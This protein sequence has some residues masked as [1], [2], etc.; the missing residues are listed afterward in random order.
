M[1]A[2][3]GVQFACETAGDITSATEVK[4]WARAALG[5]GNGQ[6]NLTV[7]FVSENEGADLN[8]RYRQRT[9]AT[10]VLSFPYSPA[11]GSDDTLFGDIAVCAPVVSREAGEQGKTVQAHCAHLVVHATL[12]LLGYDHQTEEDANRMESQEVAVLSRLG[13]ADPYAPVVP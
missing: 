9:G 5:H 2:H 10:N 6:Q 4:T 12:H 11:P 13:F 1:S 3:I 8:L 7:R